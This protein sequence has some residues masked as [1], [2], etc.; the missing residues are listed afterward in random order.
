MSDILED[1]NDKKIKEITNILLKNKISYKTIN[2]K[3][4]DTIYALMIN[5]T[6]P[7]INDDTDIIVIL[8]LAYY[9]RVNNQK[10]TCIKYLLKCCEKGCMN[11]MHSLGY[12][13]NKDKDYDNMT[14]Y[15][16]MAIERK[17]YGQ[18]LV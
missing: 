16:L 9:Y 3:Y 11:A 6:I 8:Y 13:Y 10:S 7:D 1:L 17:M 12:L 14:K 15:Y 4:I 2:D 5:N 18:C